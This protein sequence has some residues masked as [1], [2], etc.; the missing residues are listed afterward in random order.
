MEYF[1]DIEQAD[2]VAFIV[3]YRL[4]MFKSKFARSKTLDIPNGGTR[5]EP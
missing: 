2:D 5:A 4:Y 3:A 1:G